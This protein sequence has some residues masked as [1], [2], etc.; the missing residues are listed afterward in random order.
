MKNQWREIKIGDLVNMGNA[1]IKTGPF[2][3]QLKASD[4]VLEGTPLI[5]AGNVGFGE[6][7]ENPLDYLSDETVQRLS[8]HLLLP[9]DIVFGRKGTVE[10][11][12]FIKEKHRNWFQG[13]DCLRVRLN[14]E[15]LD[16]RFFSYYLLTDY[17]KKWIML[18]S[19]HGATMTSLNQGIISRIQ[20]KAP[21][22]NEQRRIASILS[23]Y[24]D[25][26]ENN[27]QRIKI[28]EE[29]ARWI[30]HELFVEF[31]APGIKLRKATSEEKKVTGKDVFPKEWKLDKNENLCTNII[32]GV[33]PKYLKGS[34]RY[35]I[36][37]K[38]NRGSFIDTSELKHLDP[39]LE[40]PVEKYA[41]YGDLLLNS[42]GEGTIGRVHFYSEQD[43]QWAVD[44]HMTI[45]RA[46]SPATTT[47]LYFVLS[48]DQGQRRLAELK[49]GGTNMTMLNI[50]ALREFKVLLPPKDFIIELWSSISLLFSVKQNLILRNRNLHQTRDLLLPKLISGE[51]EV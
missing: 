30:Y 15:E 16:S 38:A 49:T 8:I 43:K 6:V 47:Y 28:L 12:A 32:R 11:H 44:Q 34:H 25:L 9:G 26:I 24:D 19:S 46:K 29:M 3:T 1:D 41:Q 21:E 33:T 40:V 36:N 35:V 4:Y 17:H 7:R 13:T 37:Q 45:F 23:A 27:M 42:L 31:K 20:L 18:Q 14:G 48:S 39:Y 2:G 51:V 10:R 5:N 50:S 22:I